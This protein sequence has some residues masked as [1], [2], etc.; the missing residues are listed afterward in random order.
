MPVPEARSVACE[1]RVDGRRA[2]VVAS[3][4][5]WARDSARTAEL[6]ARIAQ[7]LRAL[8]GRVRAGAFSGRCDGETPQPVPRH[9]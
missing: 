5:R 4:Q 8:G 2:V 7:K 1:V 6:V 3:F 9:R